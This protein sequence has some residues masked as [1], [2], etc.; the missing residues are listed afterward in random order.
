MTTVLPPH[1][2]SHNQFEIPVS[3]GTI[4]AINEDGNIPIPTAQGTDVF[5]TRT[6]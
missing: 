3:K 5:T 6:E 4:T 2:K 1:L